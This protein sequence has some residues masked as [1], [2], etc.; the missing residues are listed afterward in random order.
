MKAPKFKLA[1][2]DMWDP[3]VI[4][5]NLFSSH[6]PHKGQGA[7]DM[8]ALGVSGQ[9]PRGGEEAAPELCTGEFAQRWRSKV[10]RGSAVVEIGAEGRWVRLR[11][12]G[13]K[14]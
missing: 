3:Y 6:P 13:M 8:R 11:L 1:D 2:N 14:R 4:V 7:N 9:R 12:Y 5:S 10:T